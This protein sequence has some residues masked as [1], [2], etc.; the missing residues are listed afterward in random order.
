MDKEKIQ[1][2]IHSNIGR[3]ART[4]LEN[5]LPI[6]HTRIGI[7]NSRNRCTREGKSHTR[8]GRS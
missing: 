6:Q 1:D 5:M 8:N 4:K 2:R 7:S 3:D